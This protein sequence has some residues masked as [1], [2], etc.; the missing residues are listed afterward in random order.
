[1]TQLSTGVALSA[2]ATFGRDGAM[3]ESLLAFVAQLSVVLWGLVILTVVIRFV[4][5]WIYRRSAART[6]RVATVVAS[7]A[8]VPATSV[9]ATAATAAVASTA[10]VEP[11]TAVATTTAV[12]PAAAGL[13]RL[14]L[15]G[16][17]PLVKVPRRAL[18]NR[19]AE[20]RS[21][22]HMPALAANSTET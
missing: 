7:S 15:F 5:I 11:A 21:A 20:P 17:T 4:G 6:A 22:A 13:V 19:R 9:S 10:A 1:M 3:F 18:R 2:Q 8:A 14:G 16:S 12:Q